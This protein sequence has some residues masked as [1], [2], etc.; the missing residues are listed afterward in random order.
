MPLT[1]D[2]VT[3]EALVPSLN[4][5]IMPLFG[6]N[7][8][9]AIDMALDLLDN[10]EVSRGRILLIT[11]GIDS[12]DE[13]L[14]IA[15]QLEGTPHELL[16]LGIGTEQGAPIRS[17][18]GNFLTDAQGEVVVPKLNRELLRSLAGR[19]GGRY[20][21]IALGNSDLT[22]LLAERDWR[23]DAQLSEVED[24]FDIWHEAGPWLLVL[25][26]PLAAL[27]FRRGWLLSGLL[28]ASAALFAPA[29]QA[30]AAEWAAWWK[31]PDQRGAAAFAKEEH[32]LAAEL[33][34]APGW[35]GAANYRAGDYDAASAAFSAIDSPTA[36]YNRGNALAFAG[37]YPEALAAYE[38]TLAAE[39]EHEDALHNRA[40]VEQLLQQQQSEQQEDGEENEQDEQDGQ[41]EEDAG[42]NSEQDDEQ[43]QD[44][45]ADED[46]QQQQD[47]QQGEAAE[48]QQDSESD[49]E[50]DSPSQDSNEQFEEQQSLEQWLRRIEDDPGELLQRKFR[51]QFRQRQLQGAASSVEDG[52]R[53][54]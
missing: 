9:A 23:D 19:V 3:I 14:R 2:V 35:Q 45:A 15:R 1:D 28:A 38:L 30:Q 40:I 10:V 29:Q 25:L 4:P 21:D 31:T 51:Y 52:D 7:P 39:P 13:Q 26:V 5:N 22:Y 34:E 27:G 8:A 24:E 43:Q 36:N 16:I 42:Q 17:N 47:E 54:W 48:E 20:H 46:E 18:D 41:S 53:I 50:Q 11:D 6:S 33:F 44:E 49:S 12:I 32:E 37:N